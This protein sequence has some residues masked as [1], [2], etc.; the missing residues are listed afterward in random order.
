KAGLHTRALP[1][2]RKMQQNGFSH[3]PVIERQ[4]VCGAFSNSTI[5]SFFLD[6]PDQCIN[7]ETTVRTFR[8]YLSFESHSSEQFRFMDEGATYADVKLAFEQRKER[9]KRLA[10]IFVTKTGS[11]DEELLGMITPWDVLGRFVPRD[12]QPDRPQA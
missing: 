11:R 8:A 5:F 10:A 4:R 3:V 6:H 1:L 12:D 9:N 2:M 7:G